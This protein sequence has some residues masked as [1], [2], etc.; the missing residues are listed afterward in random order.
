MTV[1]DFNIV[2]VLIVLLEC[3]FSLSC[4]LEKSL[5]HF[6]CTITISTISCFA[7]GVCAISSASNSSTP[8]DVLVILVDR[9]SDMVSLTSLELVI[10]VSRLRVLPEALSHSPSLDTLS[11]LVA[12]S[13]SSTE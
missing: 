6:A 11:A 10:S 9:N 3:E 13:V 5:P 12:V 8:N 1:D 2:K 7:S 4:W